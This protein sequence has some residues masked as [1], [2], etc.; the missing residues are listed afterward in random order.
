MNENE[1]RSL[2]EQYKKMP[3]FGK[4]KTVIKNII[5]LLKRNERINPEDVDTIKHLILKQK[6]IKKYK[7][8]ITYEFLGDIYPILELLTNDIESQ[9][10]FNT[11]CNKS[12]LSRRQLKL[13]RYII[14]NGI[15]SDVKLLSE[16]KYTIISIAKL[17]K[18]R[19]RISKILK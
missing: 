2:E 15:D 4:N 11:I 18:I 13:I 7:G 14:K 5:K 6:P 9:N 3:K 1:I 8:Y 10:I 12:K 19:K 17:V 16:N